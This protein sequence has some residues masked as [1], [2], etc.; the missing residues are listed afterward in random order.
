M[1][2]DTTKTHIVYKKKDGTIVAGV[3]T[4]LGMLDKPA[5]LNWAWELGTRGLDYRKVRDKAA[6]IGTIAHYLIECHLMN[7]KPDLS[8]YTPNDI[9]KAETAFLAYLDFEKKYH[10][11]IIQS[12]F[13][14]VSE[15]YGFGGTIDCY[16][17]LDGK[18][19]LLDFKTSSGLYPEMRCQ[20]A[21][22]QNLLIENG[23]TVE[24]V[25]LLRID[26]ETGE[27]N[28]HTFKD[29]QLEWELFKLLAK[30]YPLKKILWKK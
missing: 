17:K 14:L 1:T 2:K 22:Y 26:K 27:F 28:H 19:A 10:L 4:I 3:T 5:L 13:P 7:E 24:E 25:H 8:D 29:L 23:H 16:C 21:A 6:S 15:F 12:E 18:P 11:Q 20:V 30:A 9:N